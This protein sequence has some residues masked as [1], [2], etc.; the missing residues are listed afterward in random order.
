MASAL[1]GSSSASVPRGAEVVAGQRPLLRGVFHLAAAFA[2]FGG[3]GVLLL[4]AGS[5]RAYVGGAIFGAS[6]TLLYATSACYHRISWR[7]RLR[8]VMKRLDH[9]MIFVLIAGTYT[10]LSLKLPSNAW[11]ISMLS[12][13]W[14]IAG[15]GIV[16][17]VLWPYAPRWFGVLWYVM[18]GWLC[19]IAAP[20]LA[21]WLGVAPLTLLAGGGAVYTLGG[22][23]YALGWPNPWPRVFGYHEV[24]HTLTIAGSALHYS[25]L[26][27]WILPR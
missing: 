21:H 1:P 17:K 8:G 25:V 15:A 7:P 5:P 14:A 9:A 23:V 10:P 4:V 20:Q 11:G 3:T 6:L 26:A 18:L 2:A 12:V 16:V 19:L 22:V 27:I 13:V 24:F